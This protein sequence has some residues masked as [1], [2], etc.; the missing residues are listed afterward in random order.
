MGIECD[1]SRSSTSMSYSCVLLTAAAIAFP[2]ESVSVYRL[3]EVSFR[4]CVF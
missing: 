4:T 2:G 1:N 3:I